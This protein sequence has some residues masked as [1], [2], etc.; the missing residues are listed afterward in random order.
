[1]KPH[2]SRRRGWFDA[3][4]LMTQDEKLWTALIWVQAFVSPT[5][6]HYCSQDTDNL[7]PR[8][9]PIATFP[10]LSDEDHVIDYE[11]GTKGNVRINNDKVYI[12]IGT[13]EYK[14]ATGNILYLMA[15]VKRILKIKNKS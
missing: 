14:F 4:P 3:N 1:M 5:F 7:R 15:D 10:D 12:I 9:V 13:S 11:D 2:R 8:K 6:S